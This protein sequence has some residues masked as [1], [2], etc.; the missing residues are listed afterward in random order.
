V[1]AAGLTPVIA[2]TLA[3]KRTGE[4]K[5]AAWL[6]FYGTVVIAGEHSFFSIGYTVPFLPPSS[7]PVALGP[8]FPHARY[9]F[10]MSG[11][12]TIVALVLVGVVSFKWLRRGSRTGW[13]AV[14]L[15]LLIGGGSELTFGLLI[16]P[17]GEAISICNQGAC[18]LSIPVG[19]SLYSCIAAWIAALM[20]S[21]KPIFGANKGEK[22]GT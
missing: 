13:Y 17:H 12:Y 7:D 20:I 21:Y 11:I 8:L 10:F 19:V 6:V 9:H 5:A 15:A 18:N 16:Y 1:V 4:L 22:S 3:R 2:L 14:M